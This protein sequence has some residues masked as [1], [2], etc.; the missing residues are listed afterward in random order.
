MSKKKKVKG[1]PK[2]CENPPNETAC[3][4]KQKKKN[5]DCKNCNHANFQRWRKFNK[6][7]FYFAV[8]AVCVAV[9]AG[10]L[11]HKLIWR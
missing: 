2:N 1:R 9:K 11:D 8:Q 10:K 4:K 6:N 3:L 7:K 5:R